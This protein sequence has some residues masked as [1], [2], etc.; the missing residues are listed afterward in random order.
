M[1]L[2]GA[3]FGFEEATTID[4]AAGDALALKHSI[5]VNT[6]CRITQRHKKGIFEAGKTV[7]IL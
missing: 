7:I 5:Q 3:E 4:E 1:S 6:E 2:I